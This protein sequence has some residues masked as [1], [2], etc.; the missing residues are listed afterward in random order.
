MK[1]KNIGWDTLTLLAL[2]IGGWVYTAGQLKEQVG[3]TKERLVRVENKL[4]EI[5]SRELVHH[6]IEEDRH[7]ETR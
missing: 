7:G 3:D 2:T 5:F 4:D 6:T 1:L